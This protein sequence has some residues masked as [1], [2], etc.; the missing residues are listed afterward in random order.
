MN[1]IFYSESTVCELY[2]SLYNCWV[3][4]N[5]QLTRGGRPATTISSPNHI[6]LIFSSE[7]PRNPRPLII[8]C[9]QLSNSWDKTIFFKN[10]VNY[11]SASIMAN[12]FTIWNIWQN[13]WQTSAYNFFLWTTRKKSMV[14]TM[15]IKKI[16]LKFYKLGI[17]CGIL[18]REYL[19]MRVKRWREH[20][21]RHSTQ[22]L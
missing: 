14:F 12:Q 17:I 3:N 8:M 13:I 22:K 1:H 7:P 18:Q 4:F 5:Y 19:K 9:F 6:L 15:I 11:S 21:Q 2:I 16:R 20:F 10:L